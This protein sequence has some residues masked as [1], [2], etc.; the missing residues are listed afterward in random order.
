LEEETIEKEDENVP[1]NVLYSFPHKIGAGGI[2]YSAWHQVRAL[3]EVGAN[4]TVITGV[5]HK[6]LPDNVKVLTTLSWGKLR[7]SYKLF[8]TMRALSLHDHIVAKK[9]LKEKNKYDII[10]VWPSAALETIRAANKVGVPTVLE[11]PNAHTR[12]AYEAVQNESNRLGI[13]LPPQN[14]YSLK[15]KK[16]VLEREE[17]EF[18]LSYRI[19]CPSEF[20]RKSFV[21]LGYAPEKLLRHFRG[22]DEKRYYPDKIEKTKGHAFTMLFVGA[23]AVRKGLH[24]ALEA[25][26]QSPAHRNGTF[27]IAGE[28]LPAYAEKLSHMLSHPSVKVLGERN[29][30]PELMRKSDVLVLP[31][32]EEGFGKVCTEAMSS[33]CIPLVSEACTDIC[34]HMENALVHR[35]GDAVTLQQHI[36]LLYGD[37]ALLNNLRDQCLRTVPMITWGAASKRLVQVYRQVIDDYYSEILFK[38]SQAAGHVNENEIH[39]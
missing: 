24:F 17:E 37:R 26:L 6:P 5:L 29:D 20:T 39:P 19:V 31:S 28:F 10:H 34:K 4:V 2:C 36:T 27:L 32:I 3:S 9:V 30:V 16:D 38:K 11:R 33:G 18:R 22:V 8:G 25:W 14:E 13:Q 23:C 1:V 12:Y 21:N 35:I 15:K 7:I